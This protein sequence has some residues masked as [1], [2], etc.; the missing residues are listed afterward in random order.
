GPAHLRDEVR[1]REVAYRRAGLKPLCN[2]TTFTE[3][4]VLHLVLVDV[5]VVHRRFTGA[6][7]LA[8]HQLPRTA[9]VMCRQLRAAARPE[10]TRCGQLALQ[11]PGCAS[12]APAP[13][14]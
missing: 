11:A 4:Q 6:A 3:M 13:R 8:L 1:E 14:R 5:C 2:G 9:M 7:V 10:P 12:P